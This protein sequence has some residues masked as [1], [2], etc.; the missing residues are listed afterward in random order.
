MNVHV[1]KINE[2]HCSQSDD[3]FFL[4]HAGGER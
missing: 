1:D 2:N 3:G 4:L